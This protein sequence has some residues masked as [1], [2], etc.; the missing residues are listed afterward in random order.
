M[1]DYYKIN[2]ISKFTESVWTHCATMKSREI[3]S[4]NGL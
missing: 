2:K 3:S 4:Q 1:K